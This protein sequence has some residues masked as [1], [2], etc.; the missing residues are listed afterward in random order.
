MEEACLRW[1]Q[2][3]RDLP[4]A[5]PEDEIDAAWLAAVQ[6]MPGKVIVLDD[7]PTG[8]QT[9]HS[10]PVYTAWDADTLRQVLQDPSRVVY[11]LTNSRA[12]TAAQ[13]E[14]LHSRLAADLNRVAAEVDVRFLLVSRGDSTLRGHYPLETKVLREGLTDTAFDGEII[15]PFFR[16]GGRV[17]FRD[18]HYVKEGDT[19]LPAGQTEFARDATFGYSASDLREWIE[20][21]TNGEYAA[22]QVISIGLDTLRRRD[23]QA[24][25]GQLCNVE[26]FNKVIVNAVD[27]TDLKVF[28]IGLGEALRQGKQFLFR[29]AASF[30]RAV[31]G[32]RPKPLL[33]G[34]ALFPGDRPS[35]PGLVLVGSYVEKTTR[36]LQA[37]RAVP[38]LVWVE[39]QVPE[40]QT[41]KRFQAEVDRV[42]RA[43]EEALTSG[44]D[45]CVHTSRRYYRRD[46]PAAKGDEDLTFSARVSEG[47]VQ[48]VRRLQVPPGFL[49]AKGGITSSDVGVKGLG[50]RRAMVMGQIA[51][52]VPAWELGPESRFPG[53]P[54]VIFPGNVGDDETLKQVV[55]T[56]RQGSGEENDV[57]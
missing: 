42:A 53:L 29:T 45:V 14:A 35:G 3:I 17:T 56:L 1:D 30:V 27:D 33:R 10:V 8:V 12:V 51:P 47:L 38:G 55:E 52:G 20:E 36:Q 48:V 54:Y 13:T 49:V 21:K 32:I 16:E 7:D 15:V 22:S 26:K 24:V 34:E 50:V 9:V 4:P 39:W 6:K 31:G 2:F 25:A 18:V 23:I 43:V 5:V 41:E 37:L 46:E 19:L 57:R 11:V 40:A 28:V 44:S